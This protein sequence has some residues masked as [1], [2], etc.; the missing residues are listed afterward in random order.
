MMI[1]KCIECDGEVKKSSIV[2]KG[3]V[4][5]AWECQKCGEKYI[6][7]REMSRYEIL[8]GRRKTH[9][10]KVGPI[11]ASLKITIPK[12][13]AEKFGIGE[14]ELLYFEPKKEGIMMTPI[15]SMNKKD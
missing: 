14:G 9:V 4:L 1:K 15:D 6:P 2:K 8:T 5:E 13:I 7:S 12:D 11:G 10:R 3:I